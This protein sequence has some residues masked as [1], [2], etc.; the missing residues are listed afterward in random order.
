M[1][2][3]R[4]VELAPHRTLFH[5]LHLRDRLLCGG[6]WVQLFDIYRGRDGRPE[7]SGEAGSSYWFTVNTL[8]ALLG[9]PVVEDA[10]GAMYY[11]PEQSGHLKGYPVF[12]GQTVLVVSDKNAR[13]WRPV[14]RERFAAAAIAVMRK[15]GAF[16]AQKIQVVERELAALSPQERAMPARAAENADFYGGWQGFDGKGARPVVEVNPDFFDFTKPRTSFQFIV[17]Y[18]H[19][20]SVEPHRVT[21]RKTKVIRALDLDA[22][23]RLLDR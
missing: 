14:S 18:A 4:G 17:I 7:P 21:E 13:P 23:A 8:T 15:K 12:G 10:G 19:I 1:T 16:F 9:S 6:V 20:G 22:Y 2:D 5:E 11:A 3:P